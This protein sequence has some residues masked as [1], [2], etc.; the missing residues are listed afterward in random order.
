M[1]LKYDLHSH[2]IYSDGSLT[3]E[4]L[5]ALAKEHKVDVLALTDHDTT[6]GIALAAKAA[7]DVGI[8]FMPGVE[9]SALWK[10]SAGYQPIHILGLGIDP[11]NE[12]L[13]VGLKNQEAM[14]ID[15]AKAMGEELAKKGIEGVYEQAKALAGDKIVGRAHFAQVLVQQGYAKDVKHVF[16][17]YLAGGKPGFVPTKWAAYD[18]VITWIQG[19]GGQAVL[20]HPARYKLTTAKLKHLLKDFKAAGGDGLEVVTSNHDPKETQQMANLAVQF[21]LKAS[22]GS[23][24]HGPHMPWAVLGRLAPIPKGCTPIWQ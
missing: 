10:G 6:A 13:Q 12:A 9:I 1:D 23:D 11:A 2:T 7:M 22:S 4:A 21:D 14:R 24:F 3:P 18:E 20:A 5:V 15:R 19:A 17:H 16:K 8:G